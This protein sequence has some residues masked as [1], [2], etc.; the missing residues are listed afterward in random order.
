MVVYP[1]DLEINNN[2]PITDNNE[3]PILQPTNKIKRSS[4][5]DRQIRIIKII[6]KLAQINGF[7][8]N[9]NVK[10]LDGSYNTNSNISKLL[11]ITQTNVRYVKGMADLIRLLHLSKV[12]PDDIINESVR[13]KLIEMNS[14]SQISNLNTPINPLNNNGIQNVNLETPTDSEIFN[15]ENSNITEYN[16]LPPLP[17]HKVEKNTTKRKLSTAEDN[18]SSNNK[19]SR[20]DIPF[21]SDEE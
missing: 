9:L 19:V 16:D 11:T 20:W 10:S 5:N 13:A 3:E 8:E 2:I 12:N 17:S 6:L 7:N 21:I 4:Q 1:Y 15:D 14:A 18:H